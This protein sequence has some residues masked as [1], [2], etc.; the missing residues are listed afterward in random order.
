V[1]NIDSVEGRGVTSESEFCDTVLCNEL[2]RQLCNELI[3]H[4]FMWITI[5]NQGQGH[6]V[7]L[8]F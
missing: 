5:S 3:G 2:L 4:M 1:D 8:R 7:M 6:Q